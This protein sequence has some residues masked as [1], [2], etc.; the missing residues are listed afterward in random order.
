MF[1][2]VLIVVMTS[3][4]VAAMAAGAA[5]GLLLALSGSVAGALIGA[6]LHW[7]GTMIGCAQLAAPVLLLVGLLG[8]RLLD[9]LARHAEF[10]QRRQPARDSWPTA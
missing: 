7:S 8:S 9:H 2:I 10:R 1:S 4:F 5:V 6:I 3:T